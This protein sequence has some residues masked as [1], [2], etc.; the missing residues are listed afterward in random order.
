MMCRSLEQRRRPQISVPAESLC[1]FLKMWVS[2]VNTL[3]PRPKEHIMAS[4]LVVGRHF[5]YRDKVRRYTTYTTIKG[6]CGYL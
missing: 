2:L 6:I 5:N 3:N 1:H 4:C